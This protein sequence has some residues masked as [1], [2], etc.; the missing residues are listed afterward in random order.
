MSIR[1]L[2]ASAAIICMSLTVTGYAYAAPI[3]VKGG[4]IPVGDYET[5][6]DKQPKKCGSE[7]KLPPRKPKTPPQPQ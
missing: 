2:G 6:C 3:K 5:I 7:V 4:T 1:I